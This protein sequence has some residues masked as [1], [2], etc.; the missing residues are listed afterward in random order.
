MSDVLQ[1]IDRLKKKLDS[2]RPLSS[3]TVA[4]VD[5]KLRLEVNYH[6]NAIEGNS[7]TL[8]ETRSLILHGLTA[9]GK[10]MRDHLD[11]E[12]H[13]QAVKAIEDAVSRGSKEL[14]ETF[15]R[16]LH[17]ILLKEPY[18][19]PART[20][21]GQITRCR[22]ELGAYKSAPNNVRTSTGEIY[23]FTPPEQ[24]KP[25]M[26]DLMDWYVSR[27]SE[28]EHPVI[29]AAT[30]HYRFVRIH[31]FDDGN[32]RMARLLMNMI[33]IRHGYTVAIVRREDRDRYIQ[34]LER[35]D[36]TDNLASFIDYIASCCE[37]ALEL[38]LKA[39]RGEPVEDED[40]IDR[41]ITLFKQSLGGSRIEGEQI[42]A[43][44]HL[45]SL[46]FPFGD[47]CQRK[48]DMFSEQFAS[49]YGVEWGTTGRDVEGNIFSVERIQSRDLTEVPEVVSE[50]SV[51]FTLL[52]RDFQGTSLLTRITTENHLSVD[53][54]FWQFWL[55]HRPTGSYD[56]QD[57]EA[58]KRL[59]DDLL[60]TMMNN[61]R[62]E[63]IEH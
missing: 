57:L 12:G 13:N 49:I 42:A 56:G 39:G 52:L 21:D 31:P 22:I 60:R 29:L 11:I 63:R 19:V 58:L 46:V 32:G 20:P 55:D 61:L 44:S 26:S 33:L 16:N 30:F 41:E 28:G 25:A 47:Y 2:L 4:R 59:F 34:E 7:L 8:G 23:H 1:R 27:E 50:I 35:A 53:K 40:D 38:H 3:E 9:H 51:R 45:D 17:V 18:E 5:Q 15:I 24:T 6:S 14:T 54:C 62:R 10:P 37:Y 36:Q 43:R 48:L